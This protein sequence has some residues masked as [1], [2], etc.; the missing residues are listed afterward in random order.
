MRQSTFD[1]ETDAS[2][3]MNYRNFGSYRYEY[4]VRK[5][6]D[7]WEVYQMKKLPPPLNIPQKIIKYGSKK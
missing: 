7:K 2:Y 3:E 4:G 1:T 6:D 5:T